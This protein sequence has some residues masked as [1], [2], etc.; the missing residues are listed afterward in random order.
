MFSVP[1]A[2]FFVSVAVG[3]VALICCR[4]PGVAWEE[5]SDRPR[6]AF[7]QITTTGKVILVVVLVVS[8]SAA[9]YETFGIMQDVFSGFMHQQTN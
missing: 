5:L 7:H 4:K 2:V 6:E 3:I 9:A 8:W 1:T